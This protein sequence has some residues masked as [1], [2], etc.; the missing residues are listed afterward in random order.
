MKTGLSTLAIAVVL[1]A[2]S[3]PAH[4]APGY[5]RDVTVTR[6]RVH[7]GEAFLAVDNQPPGTCDY[8]GDYFRFVPTTED[9]KNFLSV[10]LAARLSG[11]QIEVWYTLSTKPGTTQAD[12]DGC[13]PSTI[14]HLSGVGIR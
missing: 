14:A 1:C 7:N 4:A 6:L 2:G 10:L 11:N 3:F 12:A 9:G 5:V 8:F 13:T